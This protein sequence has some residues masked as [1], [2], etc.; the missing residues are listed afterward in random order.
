V[1]AAPGAAPQVG[2]LPVDPPLGIDLNRRPRHSTTVDLRPGAVLV[3]YTD[4]LIERRGELIDLG[5]DRLV[6]AISPA[7][8]E[9]LCEKI[10]T[11]AG[12]DEPT[13]DVALLVVRR[14]DDC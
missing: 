12:L 2:E 9:Q 3:F 10:M 5:I 8:A 6:Q 4:G 1:L 7:P 11:A 14:L 13:D